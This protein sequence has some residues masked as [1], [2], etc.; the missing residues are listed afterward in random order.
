[1]TN[2]PDVKIELQGHTNGNN[3][4]GKNKAYKTM[5]EEWNFRGS[6]KKLSMY[7]AE[8]IKKYL[9]TKG[10]DAK[11]I[12]TNGFGGDRPIVENPKTLDAIEKNI[13]VEV[14]IL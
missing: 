5:G 14:R 2:N 9:V 10:I 13:R 6:S 3:K 8:A 11:R 4:I 1:M 12:S 7:R